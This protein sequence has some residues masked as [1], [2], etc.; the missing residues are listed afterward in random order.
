VASGNLSVIDTNPASGTF[1]TVIA[2][3][4]TAVFSRGIAITP[5][6]ARAYVAVGIGIFPGPDSVM[7]VDTNPASG[8]F[9]TVLATITVQSNPWGVA[10]TPDGARVYVVNN[11]SN[12]VSVINTATNTVTA[13]LTDVGGDPQGIAI[14]PNGAKA[15]VASTFDT[16]KVIDT[17]PASG[18]F[19]TVLATVALGSGPAGVAITPAPAAAIPGVSRAGVGVLAG[20]LLAASLWAFRQRRRRPG[21]PALP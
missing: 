13:T 17:D 9:H 11:G 7:V 18:T 14:T 10:I 5:N 20:L 4:A 15:F 3:V 6:G 19:H 12:T 1:H 2:T 16:A 21:A 8:T